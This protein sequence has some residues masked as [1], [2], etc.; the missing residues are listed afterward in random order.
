M[1]SNAPKAAPGSPH[2][3]YE[4][5]FFDAR[6]EVTGIREI[7]KS[8]VN[9]IGYPTRPERNMDLKGTKTAYLANEVEVAVDQWAGQ[10]MLKT[11]M[12]LEA[13]AER[14][15]IVKETLTSCLIQ[16]KIA[17]LEETTHDGKPAFMIYYSY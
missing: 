9:H 5:D 16:K 14:E 3:T 6:D 8:S 13:D 12:F 2:I 11:C 10:R 7:V 15:D 4:G 1:S 17:S